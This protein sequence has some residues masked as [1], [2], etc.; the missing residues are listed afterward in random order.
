MDKWNLIVDV[1]RCN[2]CAACQLATVDEYQMNDFPGYSAR[3]PRDATPWIQIRRHSRGSGEH[4]DV[5]HVPVMCQHCD[6]APCGA[7][8]DDAFVKRPDGIVMLPPDKARGRRDL[9]ARCPHGA[10]H[11]NE[12]L[13]LPQLWN[14]DAHLLDAGLAQPRCVNACPSQALEVRKVPDD[15]M[16]KMAT[17]EGLTS[18]RPQDAAHARVHYRHLH[19]VTHRFIAGTVV[20]L[21]GSRNVCLSGVQVE[22]SWS[23]QTIARGLTDDFGDFK[24][25]PLPPEDRTYT[26]RL[27]APGHAPTT[28][29]VTLAEPGLSLGRLPLDAVTTP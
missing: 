15:T 4:I 21:E 29:E 10:I 19:R 22:L 14:F 6:D 12:E 23:G 2:N 8:R 11:W 24:L 17:A 27:T 9:V 26:L 13:Q 16:Q 1:A 7:G 5:T 20:G 25:Q 18:L 3:A 28:R